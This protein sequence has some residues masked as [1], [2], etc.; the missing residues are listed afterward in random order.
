MAFLNASMLSAASFASNPRFDAD[1][2]MDVFSNKRKS[3]LEA[4]FPYMSFKSDDKPKKKNY[5]EY[6]DRLDRMK[7]ERSG[8]GSKVGEGNV[9]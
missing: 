9:K 7:S 1:A 4:M 3:L 2:A 8:N 6:F 5:D